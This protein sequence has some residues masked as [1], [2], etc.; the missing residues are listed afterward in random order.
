MNV[1]EALKKMVKVAVSA[2]QMDDA[3]RD[4]GYQDTPYWD[5]YGDI[6]DAVY[7]IVG[8]KTATIDESVTYDAINNDSY[9][10]RERVDL[11]MEEYERNVMA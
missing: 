6:M 7:D 5:I 8:E 10:D 4:A 2:R 1:R 11:L 9:T 3:F